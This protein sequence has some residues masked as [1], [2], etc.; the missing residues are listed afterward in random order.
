MLAPLPAEFSGLI[1]RFGRKIT[2]AR[3]S[4]TDRCDLR[5]IYCVSEGTRFLPRNQ[6]LTL[7]E[8]ARI[9]RCL[10]ELGITKLRI[11]GGE[12]LVRRNAIWLFEQLG[13]LPAL[14]D[15]SITTNGTQLARDACA[16]HAAGVTR[17]NISLDS[18]QPAR[19]QQLTR[20]GTLSKTLNGIN[21]AI[22]TGFQHIKLNSVILHHHN[23]DEVLDLARFAI[24]H[25]IDISFIEEMPLGI[26]GDR[27]ATYYSSDAIRND[28]NQ[29]FDL[30][31]TTE[32]SGGPANYYRIAGTN[33]RI[34]FISPYS[35]NF[36]ASCNRIRITAAGSLLPC[37][38]QTQS[39]DLRRVIRANPLEDQRVKLAIY[40]A[41][42]LK[43]LGHEFTHAVTST[44]T[45]CM[46][47]TGG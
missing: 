7:E 14:H 32:R 19:F 47:M 20:V 43:P 8:I 45:R 33:S 3:L 12:P 13:A 9:G 35:H 29:A 41:V 22:R 1:D 46:N 17:V 5:C 6:L 21:A 18:L 34:G 2:Y 4:I 30:I 38:G 24:N 31:P 27:S 26:N 39:I 16:L 11:T 44:L 10:T 15:L 37:L 23:H 28:L 42:M 40:T 25:G 36:C